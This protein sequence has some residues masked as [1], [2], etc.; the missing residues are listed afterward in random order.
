[1]NDALPDTVRRVRVCTDISEVASVTTRLFRVTAKSFISRIGDR[2]GNLP[3]P[4]TELALRALAAATDLAFLEDPHHDRVFMAPPPESKG[5]RLFSTGTLRVIHCGVELLCLG[6]KGSLELDTGKQAFP[7]ATGYLCAPPGILELPFAVTRVDQSRIRFQWG[8][9]ARP[10]SD[11]ED[12][13]QAIRPRSSVFIWHRVKGI[14]DCST[15]VPTLSS[16]SIEGS[17]FPSHRVWLDGAVCH[18]TP[19]GE[20]AELWNPDPADPTRV[21]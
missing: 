15:G 8:M 21:A 14:V 20:L 12:C 5:Y 10:P 19:Q 3:A 13:F 2:V 18:E 4:S 17:R 6:L 11:A 16:L 1:M 7:R 9:K